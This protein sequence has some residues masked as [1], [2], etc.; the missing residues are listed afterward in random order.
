[1]LPCAPCPLTGGLFF[2]KDQNKSHD[3]F[4]IYHGF[5]F[6]IIYFVFL[7]FLLFNKKVIAAI[8]KIMITPYIPALVL[9]P[10]CGAILPSGILS[11]KTHSC[12]SSSQFR[13]KKDMLLHILLLL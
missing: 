7:V 2:T 13:I 8:A 6:K 1:L 3:K 9:S 11:V 5:K 12:F 4:Y 10:V